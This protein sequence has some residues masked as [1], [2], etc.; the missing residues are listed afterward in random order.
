[1]APASTPPP[2]KH[3]NSGAALSTSCL[4]PRTRAGVTRMR[5]NCGAVFSAATAAPASSNSSNARW[6]VAFKP[7]ALERIR[8]AAARSSRPPRKNPITRPSTP[9]VTN[10]RAARHNFS[11]SVALPA[12]NPAF[13]RSITRIGMDTEAAI[14][15]IR[16]TGGVSPPASSARTISRRPAPPR[17]AS[18]ASSTEQA[19]TSRIGMRSARTLRRLLHPHFGDAVAI[20]LEHGEPPAFV[21]D[22]FSG[23]RNLAEFHQQE[24]GQGLEAAV[25][26]QREA[27][28]RLH[29]ADFGGTFQVQLVAIRRRLLALDIVLVRY[30][31]YHLLQHV[32]H[33]NQPH[34]GAKLV[35]HQGH[36]GTPLL[37]F[38]EHLSHRLG[39]RDHQLFAHQSAQAEYAWRPVG[40]NRRA[41]LLPHRQQIFVVEDADDLLRLP[42]VDRKSRMLV[43][44]H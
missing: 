12:S 6:N 42:V 31:P 28:L 9:N 35:H 14:S 37:K 30:R 25:V 1:M 33:G 20:H 43:L 24:S 29:I 41:P 11:I 36:M 34:N 18:T 17:S 5:S 26:W 10:S 7:G 40:E 4:S 19:M 44:D 38:R 15:R 32:F 16:E 3:V 27:E 21:L 23:D 22:A 8:C 39:I 2:T 13:S